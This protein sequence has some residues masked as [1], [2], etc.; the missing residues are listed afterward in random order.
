MPS[1]FQFCLSLF[2]Y[3]D[4]YII[5]YSSVGLDCLEWVIDQL[6]LSLVDLIVGVALRGLTVEL[7][8]FGLELG[9]LL[10]ESFLLL[11]WSL[12]LPAESDCLGLSDFLFERLL[13]GFEISI[14]LLLLLLE[15]IESFISLLLQGFLTLLGLLFLLLWEDVHASSLALELILELL[16]GI[17]MSLSE[18]LLL[19]LELVIEFL[20]LS[21]LLILG[22]LSRLLLGSLEIGLGLLKN[23]LWGEVVNFV[24]HWGTLVGD[25]LDLVDGLHF[26]VCF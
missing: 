15:L 8:E 5:V 4:R 25:F 13:F 12:E 23:I 10:L 7:H 1:D 20:A 3:F 16:L 14:E 6:A 11:L 2:L 17:S 9:D 24:T 22:H 18:L 21:F 26:K 19:R